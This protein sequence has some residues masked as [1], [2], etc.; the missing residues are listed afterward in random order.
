MEI[1]GKH[2]INVLTQN[3]YLLLTLLHPTLCVYY[4][5]CIYLL[6]QKLLSLNDFWNLVKLPRTLQTSRKLYRIPSALVTGQN[7]L[8]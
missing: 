6:S 8:P 2:L 1:N 7:T 4:I 3:V 5:V